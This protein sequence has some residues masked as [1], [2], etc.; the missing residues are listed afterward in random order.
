MLFIWICI[1]DVWFVLRFT[2]VIAAMVQLNH[3]G[4]I[5]GARGTKSFGED[6]RRKPD[7]FNT[8]KIRV[9]PQ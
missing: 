7:E 4:K 9:S 8:E 1:Q 5:R 2:A 3:K 6:L